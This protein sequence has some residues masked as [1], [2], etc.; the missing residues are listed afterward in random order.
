MKQTPHRTAAD[1]RAA[2]WIVGLAVALLALFLLSFVL[3]R[4][5]VPIWQVVRI[6]LSKVFPMEETWTANMAVAATG[7]AKRGILFQMGPCSI[8]SC[9]F[10]V[11]A[12][13]VIYPFHGKW[14]KA[15]LPSINKG[16]HA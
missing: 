1:R 4:Y 12:A 14:H 9:R 2:L 13:K 3:G 7:R 10:C 6:L 15:F 16:K 8:S 11:L 5:D